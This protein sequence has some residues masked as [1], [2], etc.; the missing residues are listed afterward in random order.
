[1]NSKKQKPFSKDILYIGD[2]ETV[3]KTII[4]KLRN[5]VSHKLHRRGAVVGISGGIDS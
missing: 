3:C 2:I 5:D 4:D 1:M